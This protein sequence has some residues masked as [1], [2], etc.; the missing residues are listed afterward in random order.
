MSGLIDIF[1]VKYH[2]AFL[3][4]FLERESVVRL[5]LFFFVCVMHNWKPTEMRRE[6]GCGDGTVMVFWSGDGRNGR[7]PLWQRDEG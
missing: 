4:F 2:V 1:A 5:A 6:R 3:Y 7:K